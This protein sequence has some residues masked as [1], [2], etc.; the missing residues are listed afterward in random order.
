MPL[1]TF[2]KQSFKGQ[3]AGYFTLSNFAGAMALVVISY[4]SYLV[5]LFGEGFGI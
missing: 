1:S 4:G 3:Y 2:F 5:H